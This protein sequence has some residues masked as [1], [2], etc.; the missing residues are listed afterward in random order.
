MPSLFGQLFGKGSKPVRRD[1]QVRLT[2]DAD[3]NPILETVDADSVTLARDG[4]IDRIRFSPDRFY[5]CGCNA[6]ERMGGQ[7]RE[8]GC[9]RVSCQRCFGRCTC[10]RKPICLEHTR[11]LDDG[12]PRPVR[13]CTHC[14]EAS[15]RTR[16]VSTVARWLLSPFVIIEKD[17]K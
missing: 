5:H 12:H 14:Y 3:G 13:L 17:E 8:P 6:E 16:R 1:A 4:S 15:V 10:C 7:C 11:Y 9:Q 2:F